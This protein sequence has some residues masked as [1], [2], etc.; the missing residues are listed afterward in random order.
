MSREVAQGRHDEN[1]A[2]EAGRSGGGGKVVG[3]PLHEG[4]PAVDRVTAAT[5]II[6]TPEDGQVKA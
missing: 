1:R 4:S 2:T 3:P 5:T 6:Q